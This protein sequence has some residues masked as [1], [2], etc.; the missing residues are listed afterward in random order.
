MLQN[1]DIYNEIKIQMINHSYRL[2]TKKLGFNDNCKT[3]E[4]DNKHKNRIDISLD[5]EVPNLKQ[6]KK[7]RKKT[8]MFIS[9]SFILD[10]FYEI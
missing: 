2:N 10:V 3:E 4:G 1:T 9:I 7:D 6:R 5:L 8:F